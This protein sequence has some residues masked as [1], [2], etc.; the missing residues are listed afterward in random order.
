MIEENMLKILCG[1][2]LLMLST[3]A[4][5]DDVVFIQY[6]E[7]R[8]SLEYETT[9]DSITATTPFA[10]A[11]IGKTMTSVALLRLVERDLIDLDAAASSWL[12]GSVTAGLGGLNGISIRHLLGMTSGLPDYY[13]ETY[14]TDALNDPAS[15]QNPITALSYAYDEDVLFQPGE[16]FDYSNTNYVLAGLILEKAS[17]L[18]F[19]SVIEREIFEP[20]GMENSF[21][22]GFKPL[23]DDFPTGHE[24]G[25]HVR[26]YYE[27]QGFGD[28]GIISTAVDLAL[29]YRVL[30]MEKTLLSPTLMEAFTDDPLNSNYGLGIEVGGPILGHSGGDLGFSSDARIDTSTG[31]IA[32][33]FISQADTDLSWTEEILQNY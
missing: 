9:G 4:Q 2:V 13:E 1:T 29:F 22:F 24:T 18:S 17:G 11:S 15:I 21:V 25:E 8:G 14:I 32:I 31:S 12:P 27:N 6:L 7:H 10:I 20:T 30:F 23:P 19:E 26:N 3:I 33:F 5:A 28:G 16:N